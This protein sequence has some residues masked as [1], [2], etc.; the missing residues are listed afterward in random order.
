MRMQKMIHKSVSIVPV[1]VVGLVCAALFACYALTSED[2]ASHNDL[3][4][5]GHGKDHKAQVLVGE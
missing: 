4:P 2:Y 3:G 5:L 1:I